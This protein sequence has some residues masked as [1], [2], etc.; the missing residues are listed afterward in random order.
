MQ[1]YEKNGV[2]A[3]F[4]TDL[5]LSYSFAAL[6]GELEV[7]GV[8]N[9]LFDEKPPLNPTVQAAPGLNPPYYV[10]TY[11]LIG[12][13]VTLGVRPGVLDAPPKPG[14]P[15]GRQAGLFLARFLRLKCLHQAIPKRPD[16]RGSLDR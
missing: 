1:F 16:G 2:P 6:S 3:V 15:V 7:F 9:N 13:Y 12:R 4:Y 14:N 5:N 11:D 8:V 10:N